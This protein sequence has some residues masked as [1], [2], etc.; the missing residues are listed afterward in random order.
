MS[1]TALTMAQKESALTALG[2]DPAL[3]RAMVLPTGGPTTGYQNYDLSPV[4]ESLYPLITPL[5]N[6]TAR[7]LN[8]NGGQSTQWKAVTGINVNMARGGVAEGRRGQPIQTTTKDYQLYY[9]TLGLESYVTDEAK[10]A[11][12]GL[13]PSAESGEV[14]RT[15]QSGMQIEET[16]MIGGNRSLA[17]GTTPTPTVT[18]ATTTGTIAA[19][20]YQIRCVALTHM[21]FIDAGMV[22]G[23]PTIQ[24]YQPRLA[25]GGVTVNENLGAAQVSAAAPITTTGATSTV[26]AT[27]APVR[28]AVAYAWF[29]GSDSGDNCALAAVTTV[30]SV[31]LLALPAAIV[32][33]TG[34]AS[35]VSTGGV[36]NFGTDKSR[37]T[38]VFDGFLTYASDPTTGAFYEALAT[39]TPG[40]GTP[41]TKDGRNGIAECLRAFKFFWDNYRVSPTE[42]QVNAQELINMTGALLTAGGA[43]LVNVMVGEGI[44]PASAKALTLVGGAVIGF[45]MNP[46]SMAGNPLIPVRLHP[47]MPAGTIL[48]LTD[49]LPYAVPGLGNLWEFAVQEEWHMTPW[50]RVERADE[51]GCYVREGL[52]V[53]APFTLG[54]TTNIADGLA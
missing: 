2:F 49:S 30:N 46:Y 47:S 43:P 36:A 17:L 7:V 14:E 48:Y 4:V 54:I 21:A 26:S 52:K 40:T 1:V 51:F 22:K 12:Q 16:N 33:P 35:T 10:L 32:A 39:G 3:A 28:G 13:S 29:I 15:L 5:R 50:V 24:S 31:K 34:Y 45:L 41:L 37:D 53:K 27:V 9:A 18:T 20:T 42:L 38:L 11:A 6:R 25:I 23:I 44:T 8:T 19:A